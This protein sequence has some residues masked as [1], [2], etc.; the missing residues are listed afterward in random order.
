[1]RSAS[2]ALVAVAACLTG[3]AAA[4]AGQA[5]AA[6]S[7]CRAVPVKGHRHVVCT[8]SNSSLAR[9][10]L[11]LFFGGSGSAPTDYAYAGAFY[12][13]AVDAGFHLISVAYPDAPTVA[14]ACQGKPPSCFGATRLQRLYDPRTGG[15]V[16]FFALLAGLCAHEQPGQWC[17]YVGSGGQTQLAGGA[18]AVVWP[19]VVSAGHSQGA[20]MSL[21]VGKQ[22]RLAGVVQLAGVDDV[23]DD[24]GR[25]RAAPWVLNASATP[26]EVAAPTPP[27]LL[28]SWARMFPALIDAARA[29][30]PR[31]YAQRLTFDTPGVCVSLP[32]P[33]APPPPPTHPP[34]RVRPRQRAR[35]LLRLLERQL[36]AAEHDGVG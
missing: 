27:G 1:M 11:L 21:L 19:K 34:E 18:G 3:T 15:M 9:G 28:P 7:T 35:V 24:D 4:A 25:T 36:A 20:G 17:Q 33:T 16:G 6:P 26:P 12:Q 8:P 32:L 29:H 23:Y 14:S 22:H 5:G 31:I 30:E 13:Q 2:F 10:Q